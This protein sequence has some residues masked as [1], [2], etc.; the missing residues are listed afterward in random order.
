MQPNPTTVWPNMIPGQLNTTPVQ[1]TTTP[2]QPNTTPVQPN[3]IAVQPNPTLVQLNAT[4]RQPNAT[5]VSHPGSHSANVGFLKSRFFITKN[6]DRDFFVEFGPSRLQQH[7][8][9][10]DESANVTSED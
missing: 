9:C 4:P 6:C 2:V 10:V 1:P 3:V 8:K 5:P 7:R